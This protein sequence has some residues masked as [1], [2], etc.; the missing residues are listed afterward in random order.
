MKRA[1]DDLGRKDRLASTYKAVSA[2]SFSLRVSIIRFRRADGSYEGS[3]WKRFCSKRFSSTRNVLERR[4]VRRCRVACRVLIV[5]E[6]EHMYAFRF[7]RVVGKWRRRGFPAT[8]QQSV[9]R[10]WQT[11]RAHEHRRTNREHMG[12]CTT[13]CV[14][15][16][17]YRLHHRN[18]QVRSADRRRQRLAKNSHSEHR[19]PKFEGAK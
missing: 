18:Y 14:L 11:E 4:D 3:W 8:A 10:E 13:Q 1:L 12:L 17:V 2:G 7:S 5:V 9:R 19:S 16:T 15:H 6:H